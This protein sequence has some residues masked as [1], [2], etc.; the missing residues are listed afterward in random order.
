MSL[1]GIFPIDQ[2]S[3]KSKSIL[4]SIPQGDYDRLVAHMSVENYKKGEILF[5]EGAVP[6]GIF[7]IQSGKIKKYK[8]DREGREQIIYVASDGELVGHHAVLSEERY[9][10]SAATI[11][12]CV[13][14][15]IPKEDFENTLQN[16]KILSQRLLKSISHEFAVLANSIS[17]F[18]QK[19]VRERLAIALIVLREKYKED[20]RVQPEIE[21]NISRNDLANMVGTANENVVRILKEFKSLGIVHTHGRKIIIDD[22]KKLIEISGYSKH[23][24]LF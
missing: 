8:V 4:K 6:S 21:I 15:F 22:I 2:W 1:S 18:A 13:I 20:K 17:V 23:K 14:A 19:N 7:Y 10:D 5:R 24:R 12:D 11:E 9:S 3:F 16:S